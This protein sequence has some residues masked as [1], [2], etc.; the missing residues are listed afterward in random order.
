[1][2]LSVTWQEKMKFVGTSDKHQVQ[3]DAHSPIGNDSGFTPKELVA[4]GVGGC[5]AMDVVALLKK[6]KEPL[7]TLS[8]EVEVEQTENV[9]PAVFKDVVI[10]FVATGEIT[11]EKLIEAVRLSQTKYCGVSAMIVKTAPI[12]YKIVL[13]G[14]EI[15]SGEAAFLAQS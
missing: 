2:K 4:L 6:Y 1:M 3:M 11:K 13:N 10:K 8:V 15:D 5:T 12:S 14:T 9:Q 7:K